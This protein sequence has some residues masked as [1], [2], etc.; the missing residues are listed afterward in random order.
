[1]NMQIDPLTPVIGAQVNNVDLAKMKDNEFD[2][3]KDAFLE[4][5]VLFFRDQDLSVEEHIEFGA[6]FGELHIH[7]AANDYRDHGNMPPEILRIHADEKTIRTAGD[8]WHSDVSCDP[9]PPMASILKLETIPASGGDTLF[10]SMYAAYDALSP[11]MRSLLDQ[12]TATHDGGPNYRDR[13]KKLGVDVGS[14]VYPSHSHPVVRTHP[15]T[16]RK[17]LFVNS[18][19]TTHID[20]IPA[21]ESRALLDFLFAH[22]ARPMFQCR[23][24][25]ESNSI[26]LWD[27]RCAQHHAMWDYY[28]QIRS[29]RRVTVKGDRPY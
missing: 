12:L 13:A 24:R 11:Q 19:F 4:H 18:T 21:E 8:K 15:E 16:G 29:G 2:S 3:L 20:G 28:P 23:F 9:E 14:K 5:Q 27:N 17:A 22:V 26:A 10:S 25:W 6:R 1:M 7:P